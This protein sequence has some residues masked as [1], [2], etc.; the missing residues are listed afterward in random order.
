MSERLRPEDLAFLD[1][2]SASTP[3]HNVTLEIFEPGAE[4][5]DYERLVALIADRIAF[6]PRYRQRIRTV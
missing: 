4:G 6:V 3:M 5:F 2:E 1:N